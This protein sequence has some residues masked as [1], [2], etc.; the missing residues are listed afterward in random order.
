MQKIHFVEPVRHAVRCFVLVGAALAFFGQVVPAT[1]GPTFMTET[2][3]LETIPGKE[4]SAKTNRGIPWTQ[5]YS[6][7]K[8]QKKGDI[9]GVFDGKPYKAKWFVKDGH[10]CENWGDGQAC[11]MVERKDTKTLRLYENGKPKKN[12]WHLN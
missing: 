6:A 8:T 3:L 5:N 7:T 9:S 2:E 11:W 1:A 4:I 12:L 10:W